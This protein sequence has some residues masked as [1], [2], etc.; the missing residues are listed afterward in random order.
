MEG[1]YLRTMRYYR[2]DYSWLMFLV[3]EITFTTFFLI[4]FFECPGF[5]VEDENHL[6]TL[7]FFTSPLE[8]VVLV[9]VVV[10]CSK[11]FGFPL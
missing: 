7:L 3:L 9:V 1:F 10:F 5:G 11:D 4:F 6:K 2:P 8:W